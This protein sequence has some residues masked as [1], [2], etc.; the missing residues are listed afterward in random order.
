[1]KSSKTPQS[2]TNEPAT[3]RRL[4][5]ASNAIQDESRLIRKRGFFDRTIPFWVTFFAYMGLGIVLFSLIIAGRAFHV[6]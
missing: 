2:V 6:F 3:A 4:A 5:Q 1:M